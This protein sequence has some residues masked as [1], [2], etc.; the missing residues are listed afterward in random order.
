MRLITSIQ[1]IRAVCSNQKI[2]DNQKLHNMPATVANLSQRMLDHKPLP[3]IYLWIEFDIMKIIS[4]WKRIQN[5]TAV[6]CYEQA[7][8]SCHPY[9]SNS[10]YVFFSHQ[11]LAYKLRIVATKILLCELVIIFFIRIQN[12]SISKIYLFIKL[13]LRIYEYTTFIYYKLKIGEF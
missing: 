8:K 1:F 6:N 13:F 12:T 7:H 9:A 5:Y 10:V 11:P 3:N 4:T 2:R